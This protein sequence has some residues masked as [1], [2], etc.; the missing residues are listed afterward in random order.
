MA[1]PTHCSPVC[2]ARLHHRLGLLLVA[3]CLAA[4][5]GCLSSEGGDQG[6]LNGGT[7][8]PELDPTLELDSGTTPRNPSDGNGPIV[9]PGTA[10]TAPPVSNPNL[11]TPATPATPA[12]TAPNQAMARVYLASLFN[13]RSCLDVHRIDATYDVNLYNCSKDYGGQ[14]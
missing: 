2:M 10:P 5:N 6:L 14:Q 7:T 9:A 12:T 4:A 8:P 3:L 11:T 1:Y 13:G